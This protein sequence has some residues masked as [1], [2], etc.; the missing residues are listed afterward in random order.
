MIIQ[1][2]LKNVSQEQAENVLNLVLTRLEIE[3]M[4]GNIVSS[5]VHETIIK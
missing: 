3:G 2:E 4:K 1:V 5:F